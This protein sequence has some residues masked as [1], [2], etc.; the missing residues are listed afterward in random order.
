MKSTINWTTVPLIQFNWTVNTQLHFYWPWTKQKRNTQYYL[1]WVYES[2]RVSLPD[3]ER[4]I[5]GGPE[6]FTHWFRTNIYIIWYRIPLIFSVW[7]FYIFI[8]DHLNFLSTISNIRQVMANK[9]KRAQL[10]PSRL[11][12]SSKPNMWNGSQCVGKL[13]AIL[14]NS[15]K[16]QAQS[17]I[18]QFLEERSQSSP[19]L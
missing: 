12:S 18:N 3:A 16:S 9:A 11:M 1:Y 17:L 5:Q 2:F 8:I 6:R 10:S 19:W 15:F 4:H 14:G 7:N 13:F